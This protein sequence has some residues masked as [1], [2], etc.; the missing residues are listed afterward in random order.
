[1][2]LFLVTGDKEDNIHVVRPVSPVTVIDLFEAGVKAN[3]IVSTTALK[4]TIVEIDRSVRSKIVVS[5]VTLKQENVIK[6]YSG[7]NIKVENLP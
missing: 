4:E 1:M 3:V 6:F 5:A 7:W 2:L